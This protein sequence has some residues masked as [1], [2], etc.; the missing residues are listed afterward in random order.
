MYHREGEKRLAAGLLGLCMLAGLW[1]PG[2]KVHAEYIHTNRDTLPPGPAMEMREE[3]L[4]EYELLYETEGAVY[5]FREDRDIIAVLDRESGYLWKTGLDAPVAKKLRAKAMGA[6]TEEEFKELENTPVEDNMNE[7]YTDMA[8]SL[9]T[10]EYRPPE[11]LDTP[12]KTSSASSGSESTLR[13]LE[14][15][16]FCLDIDFKEID[17]QMKVYITFGEKKIQ[18]HIPHQEITGEG[19]KCMTNLYLT[20]FLGANGGQ[21]LRFNR[22]SGD[23]D[24]VERKD[25]PPGYAFVPD[26]SGA[27]IRF[28]DNN[29][30]FRQYTGDVYGSDI[31]Q[32]E[33]YNTV[34]TDAVPLKDP[35]MP[36]FGVAL[37]KDQAAFV[38]Y[39]DE[40]AEYMSIICTPEENTTYYTWTCPQFTYN[41]RYHQVFNKAGDGYFQMMEEPNV[42]DVSMTYEFLSGDGS[43]S[44]E[45][46]N[47]VGMALTY[48]KHL[49]E[50]GILKERTENESLEAVS[51]DIP[52]RLDF[53]MS[54]AES[55]VVGLENVVMTTAEDVRSI[56]TDVMDS[57]IQNINSGLQGWQKK[58][59]TFSGPGTRKYSSAIGSGSDFEKLMEDFSEKGVDISFQQDYVTINKT[60]MSYFDNAVKHVN[61]WYSY[62]DKSNLLPPTAP[63]TQFGYARPERSVQWLEEQYEHAKGTALSMTIDGIGSILTGDYADSGHVT[64][65]GARALFQEQLA[66]MEEVKKN[67]KNPGMYLWQYTDRYLQA[68]VGHSQFIFETDAVPFLQLVLNGTMEVYAP[69]AN[70]SFYTQTDILK[71]IDYNLCPAFILTRE[72]S[73]KLADTASA[74]LYSTEYGLYQDLIQEVYSQVNAALGQVKGYRWVDRQVARDGVIVNVYEKDGIV[75]RIIINYTDDPVTVEGAQTPPKSALVTDAVGT[76]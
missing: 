32:W 10:V 51:A 4:E 61:S 9:V 66:S 22:D 8:N 5:Y 24:I 58:G 45:A 16:R 42:F 44:T 33:Y 3:S 53:F 39:A 1:L 29:A 73:W 46:A 31:S 23:Y 60:M 15:N 72:P 49:T 48:R 35:V 64:V 43:G 25:A 2:E 62:V 59:V 30:I 41:V 17:L 76:P 69:Y 47:Y 52:I 34:M 38:A 6:S 21:L 74:D 20:P 11:T 14:E 65:D 28:Q 27:L 26:G 67:I 70:F 18:Y 36:V 57:G 19:V 55:G 75:K 12:K 54:D 50:Q 37:G 13:K 63:V 40:G 7:I 68:P 56:L 71:M